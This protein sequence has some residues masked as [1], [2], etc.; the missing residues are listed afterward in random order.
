MDITKTLID[1]S[2]NLKMVNVLKECIATPEM[3]TIRIATGYWDIPGTALVIDELSD[4][5][6]HEGKKVKLLIGKD[7]YVYAKMLKEPKFKQKSYPDEF[8]RTSLD[9]LADNLLDEY[10]KVLNFLLK[11]CADN[12]NQ[13][14][15]RIFKKDQDDERQFFHSKCY[16]FTSE[17]KKTKAYGI[18]GSSNFTKQGLSGNSELN[19]IED[20]AQIVRYGVEDELKGHVGWFEE[21]WEQAEDWTKEFLEQILKPSKPVQKM[22]EEEQDYSKLTP[23]ELYIKYLQMHFG[24]IADDSIDSQIKSY[25]PEDYSAYE[26]QLDAVKQCFHIMKIHGGCFLSDVVGLGKTIVGVLL[27][28]RFIEEAEQLGRKSNV[29]IVCPP[30]ILDGWKS[31]IKD[32]DKEDNGLIASHVDYVTT[33]SI[34][35]VADGMDDTGDD[36]DELSGDYKDEY[37]LILID[38]SHNFRNSDNDK[39]KAMEALIDAHPQNKHPY[40]VLLSATPQNNSPIDLYN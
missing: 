24:D 37:G 23:Y 40:V 33:G 15:I 25:I 1:N 20:S 35:G 16:I 29:L 8:I 17:T 6:S 2:S 3:D 26:F 22:K 14:E 12:N 10:K 7:P 28:R 18:I 27:I 36:S 31:T 39:H 19:Y 13:I 5:L 11:Y 4:F 38:E 9:D 32:F 21:K 30:A 34:G